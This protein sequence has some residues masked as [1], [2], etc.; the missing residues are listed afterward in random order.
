M[1]RVTTD[2]FALGE[3][4]RGQGFAAIFVCLV[5][6][7]TILCSLAFIS[8]R[9]TGVTHHSQL[10]RFS[11]GR[12]G[13]W[14]Y[15]IRFEILARTKRKLAMINGFAAE[16]VSG[17][18]VVQLFHRQ[19]AARAT[20]DGC[21][22]RDYRALQ[23]RTVNLVVLQMMWHDRSRRSIFLHFVVRFCSAPTSQT[24]SA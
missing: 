24:D 2:V 9:L 13:A 4:F 6:M 12:V 11:Y 21:C 20:F 7:A 1:T 10:F 17:M 19:A 3:L 22:R 8:W 18:K 15:R 5:E 23:L 16:T 14:S